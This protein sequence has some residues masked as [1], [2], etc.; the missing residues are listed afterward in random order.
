M[1]ASE[2]PSGPGRMTMSTP[3]KPTMMASQRRQPTCSPRKRAA[4]SVTASGSD[5][6]MAEMLASGMT[7][8]AEMKVSEANISAASRR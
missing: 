8:R 3:M 2:K 4:P 1:A 7:P 6:R 5:W